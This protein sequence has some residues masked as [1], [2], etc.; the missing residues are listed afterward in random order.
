MLSS[1]QPM[2]TMSED[3]EI[4]VYTCIPQSNHPVQG[5]AHMGFPTWFFVVW[6]YVLCMCIVPLFGNVRRRREKNIYI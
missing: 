2:S 5:E 1:F 6:T 3:R 4:V